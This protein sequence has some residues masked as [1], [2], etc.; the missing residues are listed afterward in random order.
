M[1]RPARGKR[2][3]SWPQWGGAV[4]AVAASLA[5][6]SLPG[7]AR[8]ATTAQAAASP[9][10]SPS[11]SYDQMSGSGPTASAIKVPWTQGLL[12][13]TNAPITGAN[14]D[15]SSANPTS[16]DSFMYN[17]FK[18]LVVNVSQTQDLGQQGITVTWSGGEPTIQT[19]IV[20]ADFLQM[21]ECWGD[22]TT[23]PT[24]EQCEYGSAG[25]LPSAQNAN[26]GER[27]GDT[28]VAGAT[29]P[30]VTNPPASADGSGPSDGCDPLEPTDS[31]HIAPCPGPYCAVDT[32][33]IPFQPVTDPTGDPSGLDYAGGTDTTY[34]SQFNSDE[35]QEAI[36][37][38]DGTGLQQ[39]E[40]LTGTQAPGLGCGEAESDNSPRGC[41][42]VIVPR[43][44]YEPNGYQ[45]NPDGSNSFL[46]TSPLSASNWAQRIQI[47][48]DFS[49]VGSFCPI[50]TLERQ[51]FGTQL[52]AR[53][54]QSWELSLNQAANCNR[55][56]G[57]SSVFESTS[58][59]NL[60]AGGESG[61]AFTTIPI[62]SEAARDGEP[63]PTNLPNIVYAPVA[64]AALDFGFNIN[65]VSSGGY[66]STPIKLTPLLLAKALTQSYKTDLPD[67][68]PG[69][70]PPEA[71]PTWATKSNPLNISEDTTFQ[72]LN[73]KTADATSGPLAPLLTEDHSALNQQIWQW[74]QSSSAATAWL[75]GTP[76]AND[77]NMV[78]DPDY[79]PLNLGTS[80]TI[81]SFP[82]AY[83][84]EY[85]ECENSA[86]GPSPSPSA[87]PSS[88]P[89]PSASSP[90]PAGQQLATKD[91]EDLLP[92][93]DNYDAAAAAVLTGNDPYAGVWDQNATAPNGSQGWWDKN[94]PEAIGQ[95]FIWAAD[96]TPD[97]AAFGVIPA[98][99]CNDTGQSCVSP[100]TAS[101]TTAVTSATADSSGLLQVNPASPGSGGYPLTQIIYA[102]VPTNQSAA[103]LTD[104]ASLISYAAG[105]GQTTGNAPGD[106][107]PGYL[108]LTPTLQAQAQAVVTQLQNLATA[109]PSASP[110]SSVSS[111]ASSGSSSQVQS[112]SSQATTGS[113][114]TAGSTGSTGSTGSSSTSAGAA[115]VTGGT[116]ST[117]KP[118]PAPNTANTA[119]A[120]VPG[121][122]PA[123]G[124]VTSALS[125]LHVASCSPLA[126]PLPSA[127][128]SPSST[129]S[130]SP[131][132]S[133]TCT[134]APG[135]AGSS[136]GPV[137]SLPPAEA[138]SGSTPNQP[139]GA[140]RWVL[141]ALAIA[142]GGF[143]GGGAL[144]RSGRIEI[145][146][147][148]R[149]WLE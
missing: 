120:A 125:G 20:K 19:G 25:L 7:A 54:M 37:G 16:P 59:Q 102:A 26:I 101:V 31:T 91:D 67:Y 117:P 149:R 140:I 92:Y 77:G 96:D 139:V 42:L 112:Q 108:P 132:P 99:L 142:S 133:P 100:T 80:T 60:E 148:R 135:G 97:L 71:G 130:A 83:T 123:P 5:A 144:L 146:M 8:A 41:W 126:A 75:G 4:V 63:P 13:N 124:S 1:G 78:I 143:A 110:S 82:R 48:L 66:V 114:T 45:I 62:G 95:R 6:L 21:M 69:G 56:Y 47:H 53:A 30:S 18:N 52:I 51:T 127:L 84:G 2:L 81:D 35:V 85:S 136:G 61:L 137:I 58:T 76:D 38:A 65:L 128:A 106:L 129:H 111:S 33:N 104:Y 105:T 64:I 9:T 138:A 27:E 12:D 11:S 17:D 90:C 121:V 24:P 57:Y 119:K 68:A 32:Y 36:T 116:S 46:D 23:G 86:A 70:S 88:S 49:P 89:S 115:G 141:I 44:T 28:C 87:S 73:P 74:V 109:S 34:Y 22:A 134:P 15:R 118:S 43:G 29:E 122:T 40:T 72:A 107:P 39:F 113:A 50:G 131:S 3:W 147:W 103:A 79:Q 55:I 93:I 145:P 94:S 10:P 14:D 98:E